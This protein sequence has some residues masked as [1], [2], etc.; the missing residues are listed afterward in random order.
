MDALVTS[1]AIIAS[2]A[3]IVTALGVIAKSPFG[4]PLK[5]IWRRLVA[6]PLAGWLERE[7]RRVVA[8]VVHE[9]LMTPNGGASLADVAREIHNI[10]RQLGIEPSSPFPDKW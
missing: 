4:R 3:A 10:R 5:W 2:V 9:K 6:D 8:D 7:A 1:A